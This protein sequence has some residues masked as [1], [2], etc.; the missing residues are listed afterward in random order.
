MTAAARTVRRLARAGALVGALALGA[1][2]N[3]G[4]GSDN[5]DSAATA[6]AAASATAQTA[7]ARA[8]ESDEPDGVQ[9]AAAQ[10]A[11]FDEHAFKQCLLTVSRSG[12]EHASYDQD[13]ARALIAAGLDAFGWDRTDDHHY[14]VFLF[15]SNDDAI[16]AHEERL[17][18]HVDPTNDRSRI[19]GEQDLIVGRVLLDHDDPDDEFVEV[20]GQCAEGAQR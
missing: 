8:F 4:C 20:F 18:L 12:F 10:A 3:T 14:E 6:A 5:N 9:Q 15:A 16:A 17:H 1:S 11:G 2:A 7:S 19:V 13:R